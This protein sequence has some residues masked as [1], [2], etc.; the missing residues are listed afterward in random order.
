MV[1]PSGPRI[2]N[3]S[4]TKDVHFYSWPMDCFLFS[5]SRTINSG[6][7]CL[8]IFFG[9]WLIYNVV[10]V[11]GVQKSESVIYIYIYPLF[12]RFFSYTGHYRVLSRVPCA[13]QQVLISYL[14]Y[15]Q[16]YVYVNPN[17]SIYPFP[18]LSPSNHK[19]VLYICNS[20]SFVDTFICTHFFRLHM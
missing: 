12:F 13:I 15:I 4:N 14:F 19:F 3:G 17:L 2:F 1:S 20:V 16:Q 8:K 7:L 11:T 5:F 9:I 6:F 10:L 18:S